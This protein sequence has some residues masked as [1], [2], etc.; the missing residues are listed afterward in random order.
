MTPVLSI[1]TVTFNCRDLLPRTL[2]SVQ[3]QSFPGIEH[4]IVDG[5]STDGTLDL[6]RAHA[7]RLGSW[8]SE[9]DKGIYDAMNKGLHMARGEYVLFLNAGDTFFSKDTVGEVFASSA[10]PVGSAGSK[11]APGPENAPGSE[12]MAGSE[13]SAGSTRAA[14]PDIYYGQTKIV[15]AHGRIVGDRRLRAPEQLNWKSFRYGML[16]CHQSFIVRRELAPEYDLTWRIC[17]DIDWCIRCMKAARTI[18]NTH[19]YIS[20]FLEGGFS[21]QQ[22]R[23]AWRE[24]FAIMRNHYG[25]GSTLLSHLYIIFRFL[26]LSAA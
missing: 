13:G 2:E 5:A 20:C 18:H 24:R 8:V 12:N 6:I 1:I 11:N 23:K 10:G 14:R 3:E 7:D 15:D 25:L 17:A 26:R 22:Q 9:P 16:V 19:R 21:R 4:V